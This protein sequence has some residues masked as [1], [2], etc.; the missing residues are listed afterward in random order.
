M[1]SLQ[2]HS[3]LKELLSSAPLESVVR[4]TGTVSP[5]PLGQENPVRRGWEG[6]SGLLFLEGNNPGWWDHGGILV[7]SV[8]E[9]HHGFSCVTA[10]PQIV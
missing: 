2:E 7:G 9:H 4:V 8:S 5:R 6:L 3:H 10:H 1:L